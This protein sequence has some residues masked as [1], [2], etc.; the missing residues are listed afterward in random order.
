MTTVSPTELLFSYGTLQK[1]DVQLATLGRELTG[2]ADALPG[3]A[4][5][6]V[7]ILDPAEI[8][9]SGESHHANAVPT[10]NPNDAIAGTVFE[11]TQQELAAAD[12]YEAPAAYRRIRVTL[13]SGTPAWVYVHSPAAR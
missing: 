12:L 10:G 2:R 5:R 6:L 11:V 9:S 3:Y 7:P 4:V 13:G 1:K 8:A